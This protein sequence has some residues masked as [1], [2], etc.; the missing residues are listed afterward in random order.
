MN[1]SKTD[2]GPEQ[3]PGHTSGQAFS[4][5]MRNLFLHRDFLTASLIASIALFLF[6][7]DIPVLRHADGI[8]LDRFFKLRGPVELVKPPVALVMID[9]SS[10]AEVGRW[11]WPRAKLGELFSTLGQQYH[12]RTVVTDMVFPE[13]ERN[14]LIESANWL[15]EHQKTVPEELRLYA[16]SSDGDRVLAQAFSHTPSL[17]QGFYY[18]TRLPKSLEILSHED[19]LERLNNSIL[20]EVHELPGAS[21]RIL[22]AAGINAN[23][24]LLA[25]SS[26]SAGFLN[27]SPDQDGSLRIVPLLARFHGYYL[28]S[29][30]LAAVSQY[31]SASPPKALIERESAS[32]FT[33]KH[34]IE[35]T[36]QG[37]VWVNY[38]GPAET[39][40][41][42]SA[43]DILH[44]T[45]PLDALRDKLIFVG[46]SA[47]GTQD[48]RTTPLDSL[49]PGTEVQ[50][51]IAL[52]I[53]NDELL[54]RPTGIQLI[55]LGMI[56]I[57][58]LGYGIF[59]RRVIERSHGLA[60]IFLV[61]AFISL[62]YAAFLQGIW[63][64]SVL[65]AVQTMLTFLLLFSLHYSQE[66]LHRRHLRHAFASFVDPA[67]V[68]EVADREDEIG[69]GGDERDISVLFIDVAG[70]TAMSEKLEPQEIV[71]HI[72]AFFDAATPIIF[73]NRGCIDRLTGDG[74]IALFGAPIRDKDHAGHACRAALQLDAALTPLRP[75]FEELN[76]PLS[77]RTGINSGPMV[78][79]NM[80]STHRMQY[81]FMGD[82]G[83]TAARLESL[84]KQYGSLN[85]IGEATRLLLGNR[86][87]CRELDTVQLVG[88]QDALIV[89]ELLGESDE[90]ARWQPLMQSYAAALSLYRQGDFAAAAEA[91]SKVSERFEDTVSHH[92]Q[93][94]CA[95]FSDAP[96]NNWQGVWVA[97]AK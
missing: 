4:R 46:V 22:N 40:P 89:Y 14:A 29:L 88:K 10:I 68:D 77:V 94:R 79:G 23:I 44:G 56:L 35:A 80:G 75:V 48:V 91:F 85:M 41:T 90:D 45:V 81:T 76:H 84:N 59:F 28:P 39:V 87:V 50:A 21:Q 51:H 24:P 58:W 53:I 62:A 26:Q 63:L 74:L 54:R 57:V 83:N 65:I 16:P 33:G 66:L 69:L 47:A 19:V 20:E 17:V 12:P 31:L 32:I 67:V 37:L 11:P 25:E 95:A 5:R 27:F 2:S 55:E 97:T 43:V 60:S 15:A 78:I 6:F 36:A 72:N 42:Y 49:M 71:R 38:Y 96:P 82:A 92:M 86:F 93:L 70:F 30:A 34:R 9:D 64:H 13:P 18:Y 73:Q 52:N 3:K 7:T 1:T 61:M 8:M